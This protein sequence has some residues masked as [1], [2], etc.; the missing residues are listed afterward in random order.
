M[1]KRFILW[2]LRKLFGIKSPSVETMKMFLR[3]GYIE[4]TLSYL[5]DVN[6]LIE[7]ELA[8]GKK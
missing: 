7:E 5:Q 1:I 6:N 8:K 4:D 2:F 3:S